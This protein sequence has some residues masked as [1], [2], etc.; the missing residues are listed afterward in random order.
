MA[1]VL[2][3]LFTFN[4]Y[5]FWR[6]FI[7]L[8]AESEALHG[9]AR[10]ESEHYQWKWNREWHFGGNECKKTLEIFISIVQMRCKLFFWYNIYVNRTVGWLICNS[11]VLT[12]WSLNVVVI[13][14]RELFRRA[15]TLAIKILMKWHSWP[16]NIYLLRK[17]TGLDLFTKICHD[18]CM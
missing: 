14:L 11:S 4:F 3:C 12:I 2:K 6:A 1:C 13:P 17:W 5:C 10:D 8:D 15:I 9:Y 16:V 18:I 7:V